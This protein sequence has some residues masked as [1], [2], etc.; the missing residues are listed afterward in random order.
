M[1]ILGKRHI[2]KI[3]RYSGAATVT[4]HPSGPYGRDIDYSTVSASYETLSAGAS[5][6]ARREMRKLEAVK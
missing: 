6:S 2:A 5:R 3:E 4:V 1:I